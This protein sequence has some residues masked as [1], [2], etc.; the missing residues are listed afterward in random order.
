MGL[1]DFV[2]ANSGKG[3]K[4]NG[5]YDV[6]VVGA[7]PGGSVA[8]KQCAER[9]LATLLL[10]K[11]RLPRVKVCTGMVMGPW[12]RTIIETEFGK[13]PDEVLVKPFWLSG[14]AIRVCGAVPQFVACA[15]PIAWRE[16]LDMWMVSRA[17]EKG[18]EVWDEVKV[19]GLSQ[20]EAGC[21]IRA[22]RGTRPVQL[23]SRFVIGAD[24]AASVVRTGVAP[25]LQVRY[26]A[27]L[28]FCY[29][30]SLDVEQDYCH[31]FFPKRTVRPRFDLI[32][33]GDGFLLEGSGL[34][35]LKGE[36]AEILSPFGF[37]AGWKPAWKDGC[38]MPLLHAQLVSGEFRPAKGNTLLVGDAAGMVFPVTF[39]G[40]GVAL[41]SG[42]MAA[43]SVSEAAESGAQASEL[44]MDRLSP[45]LR[46]I[47]RLHAL[48]D[49]LAGGGDEG[50]SMLALR[51]KAAYEE[52]LE[53]E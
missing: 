28:R 24:G 50:P 6:I 33:K 25:G 42:Q 13:I 31:W 19:L 21:S 32:H 23:R 15:T 41:K 9:G 1:K 2:C 36:I 40:I 51:L 29:Q 43:E 49:R 45:V 38:V 30:G 26:S 52:T 44:Y 8:A 11:K 37:E 46:V 35:V 4:M 27:P 3:K 5:M 7:G 22:R 20:D 48:N 14:H 47:G 39:E 17:I 18:V 53:V 12:A 10:E 34:R 16:D